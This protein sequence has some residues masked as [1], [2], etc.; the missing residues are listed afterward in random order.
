MNKNQ[1]IYRQCHHKCER[2][3][4]Q[5]GLLVHHIDQDRSNNQFSNF[6]VV[7]SSCHAIIHHRIANIP[8][9]RHYFYTNPYQLTF[10][11]N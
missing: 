3:G 2:C 7:C 6:E 1:K 11:F 5:N 4:S 9:F 10:N 8:K